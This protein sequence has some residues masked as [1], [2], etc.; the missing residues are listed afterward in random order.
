MTD[1]PVHDRPEPDRPAPAAPGPAAL[2]RAAED[3]ARAVAPA[4]LR[5]FRSDVVVDTKR[6]AHDVVTEHDRAA[7]RA[8]TAFLTAAVP[9]STVLG[10]EGTTG[11]APAGARVRWIVDPIDGTANFAR[12]LAY[13]CVSIAAEVDGTVAAGVVHDPVADHVFSADDGGAWLDGRPVRSASAPAASATVLTSFPVQQD[14][15]LLGETAAFDLLRD[16]TLR[17]RHHH[18]T[19]SGAL[20]LVHV[21]AGW[22]DVTMGFATHPWDVAAGALVL[23]R[24]GGWFRGFRHGVATDRAVDAEDY[25]AGGAG[26]RHE[27]LVARVAALSATITRRP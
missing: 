9:G 20:N 1:D 27:H 11:P 16:L 21:A 18:S 2:R 23:E 13:W 24:A 5:A 26:D 6:D 4:L 17:Y 19:G 8:L 3:A 25:V 14:L 7:E 10:E 12:G 15:E 22:S